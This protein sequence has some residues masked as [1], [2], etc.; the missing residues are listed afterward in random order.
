M[1][2]PDAGTLRAAEVCDGGSHYK[3]CEVKCTSSGTSIQITYTDVSELE[4]PSTPLSEKEKTANLVYYLQ[5]Y[6]TKEKI[7]LEVA[8]QGKKN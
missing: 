5:H 7:P 1:S 3:D 8:T 6:F 2:L 4:R